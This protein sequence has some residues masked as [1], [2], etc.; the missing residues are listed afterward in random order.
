MLWILFF[1]N[2]STGNYMKKKLSLSQI[3]RS[4]IFGIIFPTYTMLYSFICLLVS[5]LPL[6]YRH[7]TVMF[8]TNSVIW[9]LKVI[10]HVNYRIEGLEN[11]PRDKP[12]IIMSKHQSAWETFYLP[13]HFNQTAIILKRELAWVPFFGWGLWVTDPIV[14]NRSD[15]SNAMSQVIRQGKKYLAAGRWIL[16]FPEGTRIPTGQVG[17]YRIGGARLSVETGYPILPVA[18]NAGRYWARKQFM[19][20]PGTIHL[21]FGP[22]IEPQGRTPE[23]VLQLTKDWIENTMK[24]IDN[25]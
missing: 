24:T 6:R 15:R 12:G 25:D 9:L 21:V 19:K 11:I 8:Y 5:P 10:C 20:Y 2:V 3:I 14:I 1:L 17:H 18:H 4:L 16:V 22:I 13:G 23:E 7:R